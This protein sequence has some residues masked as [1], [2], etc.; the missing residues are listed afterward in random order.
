MEFGI[1]QAGDR[2]SKGVEEMKLDKSL[3]TGG[4][5]GIVAGLFFTAQLVPFTQLLVIV[6]VVLI[7]R[8]LHVI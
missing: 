6:S 4:V 2:N 1:G 5:L 8:Y 3:I 7:M